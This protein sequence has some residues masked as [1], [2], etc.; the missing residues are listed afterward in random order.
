MKWGITKSKTNR[1]LN[2]FLKK[3]RKMTFKIALLGRFPIKI[4]LQYENQNNYQYVKF[5]FKRCELKMIV[6]QIFSQL[7]QGTNAKSANFRAT[8]FFLSLF[9]KK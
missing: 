9:F 8:D 7:C 5:T 2:V 6:A 4:L 1:F 3:P